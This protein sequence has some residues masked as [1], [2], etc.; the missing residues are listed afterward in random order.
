M[1]PGAAEQIREDLRVPGVGGS[2]EALIDELSIEG[3][4]DGDYL[5]I[6]FAAAAPAP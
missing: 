4:D 1:E 2:L 5:L 3:S 6:S